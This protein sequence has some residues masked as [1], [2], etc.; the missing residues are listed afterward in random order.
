[1][2]VS[3]HKKL[4]HITP[5]GG[6]ALKSAN[7]FY[8]FDIAIADIAEFHGANEIHREYSSLCYFSHNICIAKYAHRTHVELID[9]FIPPFSLLSA[10]CIVFDHVLPF[11]FSSQLIH[12][13][14][15]KL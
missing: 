13:K 5:S 12:L 15:S 3:L 14:Q 9:I 7:K 6:D 1:M 8:Y 2:C 11:H 10:Q 4:S